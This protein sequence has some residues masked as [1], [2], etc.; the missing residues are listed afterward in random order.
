MATTVQKDPVSSD[1]QAGAFGSLIKFAKKAYEVLSK[2]KELQKLFS[3]VSLVTIAKE[4]YDTFF[5]PGGQKEYN[6]LSKTDQQKIDKYTE[7]LSKAL[8]EGNTAEALSSLNSIAS[9]YEANAKV[10]TGENKALLAS[11]A[12][13]IRSTASEIAK[14]NIKLNSPAIN[15]NAKNLDKDLNQEPNLSSSQELNQNLEKLV[16]KALTELAANEINSSNSQQVAAKLL[17][18]GASPAIA[19]QAL[20]HFYESTSGLSQS[21]SADLASRDVEGAVRNSSGIDSLKNQ[22]QPTPSVQHEM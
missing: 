6:L 5:N 10:A 22:P 15:D 13:L 2:N 16:D 17:K 12:S 18:M 4:L 11:K 20:S 3:G 21:Q 9:I 14:G 8:P 7:K 1:L 19:E